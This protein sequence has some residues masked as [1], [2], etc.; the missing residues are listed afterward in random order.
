MPTSATASTIQHREM[1]LDQWAQLD[2]DVSGELIDGVLEDEEMPTVLHE[3]I[4][5]WLG[6]VFRA[7][8]TGRGGLVGGSEVKLAV[9]PGRG[10]K[11]DVFVYLPGQ[12]LPS[13][14]AP[15]VEVPPSIVI[16]VVTPTPRD[17]RRDRVEKVDDYASFG[18]PFY[19]IVDPELKTLEIW[20]LNEKG[21]YVRALGASEELITEVPGCDGLTLDL[22]GLWAEIEL[23]DR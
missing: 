14:R 16:E 19:W 18:V 21:R 1:T 6:A 12:P 17:A 20:E 11:A 9:A 2:E 3:L 5:I 22:L 13:L 8:L 10:R 23:L 15:L 7:W 4:V